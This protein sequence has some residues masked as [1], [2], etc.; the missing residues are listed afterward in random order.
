VRDGTLILVAGALLAAGLLASFL[1]L[2]LRVPSLVLFLLLGMAVGSDGAGWVDFTSYELARTIGIIALGLILFEGGLTSGLIEVRPALGSAVS[3]ATVGTAL[4]AAI[5]GVAASILFGFSTLEGLLLGSIVAATDGAAIFALLRGSTLKRRLARVLEGESGMND[6][7]A[8]VLVLGFIAWIQEPG[9]GVLDLAW[10]LIRQLG[11]GLVCGVAFGRLAVEG[12][13]RLQL[14][15]V[16]LYPV[17]SLSVAALS[18]GAADALHGSGFLAV[19]VAGLVLGSA[20]IP[21]KQTITSFHQGLAWVAQV[22]LFVTLGLLVFPSQLDSV[23]PEGTL[24]ALV[25]VF[26]ARPLAAIVATSISPFSWRERAVLGWAGLR[27]AVPVVLATFPVIS[28]IPGSLDFFNIVFFAVF[29]STVLQGA[30]F[31]WLASRLGATSDE[32]ALPRTLIDAGT[33]RRMGAEVLEYEIRPGDAA[34]GRRVRDLSLPSEGL[35]NVI[36]RDERAIAPRGS[37]RLKEHDRLHVL[38]PAA[39]APALQQLSERWRS[40]PLGPPTRPKRRA[41]GV[42]PIFTARPWTEA[43]GDAAEPDAILGQPVVERL[44]HRRDRSGCFCL[45]ADGRYAVTGPLL[46]V[47]SRLALTNW[48]R[49]RLEHADSDERL[50]LKGVIGTLASDEGLM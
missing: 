49:R 3:L 2:R 16:G 29:A 22:T 35:V 45:L 6:P 42:S 14:V 27:G 25:L 4:T 40:G 31:E 11:L 44:R 43:D 10:L 15:S 41:R 28:G 21:A 26:V 23:A 32:P 18:Y 39:Q 48:V 47:G 34:V 36:V 20:A 30:T 38:I 19:Y 17:A 46:A 1:A 8:I 13:R 24:L 37:T 33:I 5:A 12:F 50:W 7:V 9:Y